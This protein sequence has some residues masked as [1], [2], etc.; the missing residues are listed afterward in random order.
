M[1]L[2]SM[3][4]LAILQ[5]SSQ[6]EALVVE[7]GRA[8]SVAIGAT[9]DSVYEEFGDRAKL[10]DLRLEG[11]LSPALELKRFGAQLV[12]SI[13]AEIGPSRNGLVVT[14]LNVLDA[15]FR[16]SAG[17]GVGATYAALRAA[18]PIDWVGSGEGSFFARVEELGISFQLDTSGPV[19]LWS[20]RD[21]AQ[22]PPDV[23]ITGMLL[24]R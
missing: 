2:S 20:I 1:P 15:A 13:V 12:P 6:E 7:R 8:G 22:I 10:V 11:H 17:I 23:R 24:T 16:T 21:P 14:R 9:A 19:R 5:V 18:Y 4:M 3:V